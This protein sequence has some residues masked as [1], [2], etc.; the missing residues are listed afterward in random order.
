MP[1]PRL[2]FPLALGTSAHGAHLLFPCCI[3]EVCPSR[4]LLQL[5]I[6]LRPSAQPRQTAAP[7]RH[8][9]HHHS[10]PQPQKCCGPPSSLQ[11]HPQLRPPSSYHRCSHRS[12]RLPFLES[13]HGARY[14]GVLLVEDVCYCWCEQGSQQVWGELWKRGRGSLACSVLLTGFARAGARRLADCLPV[15]SLTLLRLSHCR[16]R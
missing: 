2:S 4:D 5:L 16:T 1:P 14:A 9:T 7:V 3:P 12:Y 13:S 8:L 11:Q 10:P 15:P 6:L